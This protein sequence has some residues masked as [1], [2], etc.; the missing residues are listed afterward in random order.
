MGIEMLCRHLRFQQVPLD[1]RNRFLG[2]A[3]KRH[4]G[5]QADAFLSGFWDAE[6]LVD[7]HHYLFRNKNKAPGRV[8]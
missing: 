2:E 7:R 3:S 5:G 1:K 8:R 4:V 6:C